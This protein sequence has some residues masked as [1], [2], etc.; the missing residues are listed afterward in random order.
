MAHAQRMKKLTI[1]APKSSIEGVV[2]DLHRAKAMHII[3]HKASE[4]DIGSPVPK[5]EVISEALVGV[6]ALISH[7]GL[8]GD[9]TL[10]NGFR[11]VG[12]RNFAQLA[13]QVRDITAEVN[14]QLEKRRAAEEVE[15]SARSRLEVAQIL[16]PLDLELETFSTSLPAFIGTVQFPQ[17][18]KELILHHTNEAEVRTTDSLIAVITAPMHASK[19]Q[20]ILSDNGFADVS[21][22]QLGSGH[23]KDIIAS[24]NK[25]IHSSLEQKKAV[26][27][28]LKRLAKKWHDFLLL[29]NEFLALELEKAQAPLLFG[30]TEHLFMV[31]GWVPA[32]SVAQLRETIERTTKGAVAVYESDPTH[33]DDVPVKMQN[34][35]F[36]KPYEFFLRLYALPQYNEIDP[37]IFFAITFPLFFG[38]I[39]GDVGYGLVL[40]GLLYYISKKVPTARSMAYLL[41]PSAVSSIIFGLVFGE[42]FGFEEIGH[43][44]IPHLISRLHE[45]E[46]MLYVSVAIGFVHVNLGILVGFVNELHHGLKKAI[47][48]KGSWWVLQLGVLLIAAPAL[49]I[50]LISPLIGYALLAASVVMLF[51]GEGMAGVVE[52]PG[53]A[54]NIL[55]YSRLMAV[56]LASVGLSVVVDQFIVQF[57]S[58]GGVMILVAVIVGLLG[59]ALNIALGLL[60]GFLHSVR[61]HY[62]EFFTKFFKGGAVPFQPFGKKPEE[63]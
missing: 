48:A 43:Y 18:V 41:M 27:A 31:S 56:G 57:A 49:G 23:P 25:S 34:S 2:Q 63:V 29:S 58:A 40:L 7:L 33:H 4:I 62:V 44:H 26:D 32:A 61:L 42:V 3:T 5:A 14:E 60:G 20:S 55:S 13:K 46:T 37:T 50:L 11:A 51:L 22:A 30:A 28:H 45:V 38:I 15:K 17:R 35:K 9:I 12:V 10:N 59:H 6:R 53:I 52:I 8:E 39:L 16:L 54:S 21:A 24:L 1:V 47:F 36:A 19:I